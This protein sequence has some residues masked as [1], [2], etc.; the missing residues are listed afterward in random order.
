MLLKHTPTPWRANTNEVG[1]REVLDERGAILCRFPE[2]R[3]DE[4]ERE[5]NLALMVA[6]PELLRIM[7]V[8]I[9]KAEPMAAFRQALRDGEA[10]LA[11]LDAPA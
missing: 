9:D 11:Q 2:W 7:R 4:A 5:A 3:G 8:I 1:A 6:A 10:L